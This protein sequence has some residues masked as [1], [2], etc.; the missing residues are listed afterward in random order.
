MQDKC[1]GKG[2]ARKYEQMLSTYDL[3]ENVLKE[4]ED[5]LRA[6][7]K[8]YQAESQEE[9]QRLKKLMTETENEIKNVKVRFASGK[10][11]EEI[12]QVA[13]REMQNRKD[14]LTLEIEKCNDNLS[15]LEAQIP[16]IISTAC[17]LG[18]LWNEGD[19]E[20]K[21]KIQNLVYPDGISWDKVKRCYR[22]QNRNKF[23]DILDRYSIS[24]G[25][26]KGTS[27][28]EDV[29]LCGRRESN[30]YASRHQILSLACLPISTRPQT[31]YVISF[32]ERNA[33]I[34]LIFKTARINSQPPIL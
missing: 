24:Y 27:S 3:P 16:V 31:F 1:I 10:I 11:D 20:T 13:I 25:D 5:V 6:E 7:L 9:R 8:V 12:Y 4:F 23:F 28:D 22:T 15:N 29:P 32:Q 2:N 33:K 17:K 21:R 18:T 34:R 14:I 26:E 19:L 30:P